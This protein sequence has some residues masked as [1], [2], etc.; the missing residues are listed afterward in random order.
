MMAQM[1][2]T[3]PQELPAQLVIRASRDLRVMMVQMVQMV[4]TEQLAYKGCLA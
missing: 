1:A 4:L 2:L 3:G